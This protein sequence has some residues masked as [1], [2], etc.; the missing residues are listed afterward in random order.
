ME[1]SARAVGTRA[2]EYDPLAVPRERRLGV[3]P[4]RRDY[5]AAGRAVRMHNPD[6]SVAGVSP[7]RMNDPLTVGRPRGRE[8][9]RVRIRHAFRLAGR[10]ILDVEVAER[11]V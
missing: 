7:G 6:A 10:K 11:T 1:R 4:R 5:V 9:E 2:A 3:V 8:L